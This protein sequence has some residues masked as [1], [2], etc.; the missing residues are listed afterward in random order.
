[1]LNL[2][3]VRALALWALGSICLTL[4]VLGPVPGASATSLREAVKMAVAN[5]PAVLA[6]ENRSLSANQEIKVQRAGLLPRI[7]LIASAAYINTDSP[8]EQLGASS[9]GSEALDIRQ[10]TAALTLSQLLFD[11]GQRF[12]L[13]DAAKAGALAEEFGVD[14]VRSEIALL[15]VQAYVQ[16]IRDRMHLQNSLTHIDKLMEIER[17]VRIGASAG[18]D[19]G[20]NLAQVVGRLAEAESERAS[21]IASLRNS[22]AAYLQIVGQEP[23][24]LTMPD[25]VTGPSLASVT[26]A[27]Q[28]AADNNPI[29]LRAG[30]T[31]DSLRGQE[32]AAR[33]VF[34]PQL[35][36]EIS[37]SA[38]SS[39]SKE[40]DLLPP[41]S[42]ILNRDVED[43]RAMVVGSLNLY[44]GGGEEARAR[45]ARYDRAE[46]ERNY[47]RVRRAVEERIRNS[48]NEIR[49]SSERVPLLN[50]EIEAQTQVI[51]VF[52]RQF[53][54]GQRGLLNVLEERS[55]L[56]RTQIE[57]A[58]A[59]TSVRSA[60][61][62]VLTDTGEILA[63]F[64]L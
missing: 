38:E 61:Y 35:N 37:A 29:L 46:G 3:R 22:E 11:G 45:Q 36:L 20:G 19:T 52:E 32:T 48:F 49:S 62:A 4:F 24:T 25:E 23:D 5:H 55:E 10:F 26:S 17:K 7:D 43:V 56:F 18:V 63:A 60:R 9:G 16:V 41:E 15:A 51:A 54:L 2:F 57:L 13:I 8:S 47:D 40:R 44:A 30:A 1:M 64:G 33:R 12:A 42:R 59:R 50:V 28:R 14:G 34:W 39:S 31:T 58:D 6:S 21:I 53:D 27:I